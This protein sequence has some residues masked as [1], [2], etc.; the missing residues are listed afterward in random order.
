MSWVSKNLNLGVVA[1][2]AKIPFEFVYTGPVDSKYI[3]GASSMCTCTTAVSEKDR[4]TGTLKPNRK[5][6]GKTMT[7]N[8]T[9]TFNDGTTDTVTVSAKVT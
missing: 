1:S 4:I 7:K 5:Y 2:G 3:V 8:I 9:V 6:V